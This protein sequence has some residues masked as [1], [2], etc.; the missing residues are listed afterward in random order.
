MTFPPH[1][2]KLSADE[3][4]QLGATRHQGL[5]GDDVLWSDP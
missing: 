4:L 3:M 2:G 5:L 1:E